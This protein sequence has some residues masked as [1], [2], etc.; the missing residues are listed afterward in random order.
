M[1]MTDQPHPAG[2]RYY[3]VHSPELTDTEL[4][5]PFAT[6]DDRE[7][8]AREIIIIRGADDRSNFFGM[9]T[10]LNLYPDGGLEVG[11]RFGFDADAAEAA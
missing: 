8:A 7:Q 9:V 2:T 11:D 4:V 6:Q 5:G 10:W 1:T 3:L